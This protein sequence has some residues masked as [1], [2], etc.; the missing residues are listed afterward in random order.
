VTH[1]SWDTLFDP[2]RSSPLLCVQTSSS[3]R[4]F[5]L[6][7]HVGTVW[8]Q[9]QTSLCAIQYVAD[10][11]ASHIFNWIKWP[12]H[13]ADHLLLYGVKIKNEWSHT[14]LSS[15]IFMAGAQSKAYYIVLH[16]WLKMAVR[17]RGGVGVDACVFT[18]RKNNVCLRINAWVIKLSNGISGTF[19]NKF[20]KVR[21]F[22][23]P[24]PV[25]LFARRRVTIHRSKN[26][27]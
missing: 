4:Q 13:E 14:S 5:R 9:L 18:L 12:Q 2:V 8:C 6:S 20:A 22:P 11:P 7:V 10:H 1:Y 19:Q 26:C 16:C 15:H 17:E 21:S 23:T 24:C 25:R 3:A 27:R